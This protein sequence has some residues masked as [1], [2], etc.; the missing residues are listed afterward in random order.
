M[1]LIGWALTLATALVAGGGQTRNPREGDPAAVQAG[2]ALFRER[3]ADCHG[4]DAKGARGPDLTRLWMN[5]GADERAMS[6]IR[7]GVAGSIMPP[8]SAPDEEIRAIVAY[9]RSV[10]V[11]KTEAI[12]GNAAR[13]EGLFAENCARCHRINGRG[14]YL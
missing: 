8:S 9:L 12:S 6:T 14:G 10:S 7:T 11:A 4:A 2:A 5:D 3:C 13:G 1:Q